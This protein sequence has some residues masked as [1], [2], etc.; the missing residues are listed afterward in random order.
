MSEIRTKRLVLRRFKADDWQDLF[1][2]LAIPDVGRY[3]P[4]WE[5][6]PETCRE[7]AVEYS[8]KDTVWAVCLDGKMVG[9]VLL[10][11]VHNPN[12][13]I[14]EIG[15]VFNPKYHGKGYATEAC[16]ALLEYGFGKLNAHRIVATCDPENTRSW[17]LMQ[18]LGMRREAHLKKCI[19]LRTPEPGKEPNWRDEYHYA[20]LK[21]EFDFARAISSEKEKKEK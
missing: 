11:P 3:V 19:Y 17:K 13:M 6:T 18:R 5:C 4:E 14:C 21:Q 20:I 8:Q 16:K 15:F 9:H 2:Y 10:Y 1:E 7:A 12:F